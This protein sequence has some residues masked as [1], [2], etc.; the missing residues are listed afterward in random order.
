MHELELSQ[1]ILDASQL[2]LSQRAYVIITAPHM[3]KNPLDTIPAAWS[4]TKAKDCPCRV[5]RCVCLYAIK[6]RGAAIYMYVRR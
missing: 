4:L 6:V 2:A 3:P 1:H 5:Y